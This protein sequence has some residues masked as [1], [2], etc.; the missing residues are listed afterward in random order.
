MV[1][2][3]VAPDVLSMVIRIGIWSVGSRPLNVMPLP[4]T[5]MV[6]WG[7]GCAPR[8]AP[9]LSRYS[10]ARPTTYATEPPF[11]KNWYTAWPRFVSNSPLAYSPPN[12]RSYSL[13]LKI[14]T[15]VW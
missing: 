9:V 11:R 13:K 15:A 2:S 3:P 4:P 5:S 6:T 10:G 12:S 14:C 8:T 7:R 1:M